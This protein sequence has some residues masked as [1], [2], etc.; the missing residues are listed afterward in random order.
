MRILHVLSQRPGR[1]GSG[2]FFKA[3]LSE[4]DRRGYEQHAVVGG[5][6]GTTHLEVPPLTAEEFSLIA[7]PSP[8]A[9]FP[10][11]GMSDVMPYPSTVFADM[12]EVQLEQYQ[13]ACR[14][15]L[16]EIRRRFRPQLVQAHHLWLI[17]GLARQVFPD[18]PVVATAH[19]SELRQLVKAP[20][21]AERVRKGIRCLER[22]CVLTPRSQLDTVEGFR[23]DPPKVVVTGAGFSDR[24]FRP[25]QRPLPEVRRELAERY[26]IRLPETGRL[27]TFVGRLSTA[28]GVP[29]LLQ[30]ARRIEQDGGPPFRLILT[31]A[32]GSGEDG[33]KVTQLAAQ[34]APLATVLG[35]VPHRAVALLL[36]C[37]D[38]F[39]LPSL[40][41]G[42]PL[43]MLEAAACGC[44]VLVSELPTIRSW[45]SPPWLASGCFD[46]IPCLQTTQ[47]DLP[48][49]ADIPRFVQ[50]I[51]EALR[52]RL[53]SPPSSAAR[54]HFAHLASSHSWSTVFGRYEQVYRSL[55]EKP[56]N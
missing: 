5:P 27:A 56:R 32:P 46:F 49:K 51:A 52:R 34:A 38:L 35:A 23:V 7:F 24:H 41:E 37:S 16:E 6:P 25:P 48:V 31:G 21:L 15:V 30:A 20:Q 39:V 10:V 17:T 4:A 33:R 43:V 55:F 44:P 22:I 29:F 13:S 1:S 9:P 42:L 3:L 53:E 40:Y 45:V 28:K 8:Q 2:V 50:A 11:P 12:D 14:S 26:A 54:E 47:A 19:N 18:V 36:Q